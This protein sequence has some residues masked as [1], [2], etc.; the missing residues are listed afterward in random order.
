MV[1]THYH[2]ALQ[3]L[4]LLREPA[5]CLLH[6]GLGHGEVMCVE[7]SP[8]LKSLVDLVANVL[9]LDEVCANIC[10]SAP[11]WIQML[12]E[13]EVPMNLVDVDLMQSLPDHVCTA[14]EI[15]GVP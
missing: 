11:W 7:E 2:V 12:K 4:G 8:S 1:L 15:L 5:W 13:S 3:Y 9:E 14:S 6:E 10:M